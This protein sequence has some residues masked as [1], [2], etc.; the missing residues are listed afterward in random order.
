MQRPDDREAEITNLV[1][2]FRAA[3]VS[4]ILKYR[5][6]DG[7]GTVAMF[8]EEVERECARYAKKFAGLRTDPACVTLANST[9]AIINRI[10]ANTI[11]HAQAKG[12]VEFR[13]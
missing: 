6:I 2:S 12:E 13:A 1:R 8:T 10:A 3:I 4:H 9:E 5:A 7:S 11:A